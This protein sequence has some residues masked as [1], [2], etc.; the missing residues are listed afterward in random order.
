MN[1]HNCAGIDKKSHV[2]GQSQIK[3]ER[4]G[5]LRIIFRLKRDKVSG[6]DIIVQ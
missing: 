6:M 1:L 2:K 4:S 3:G 5:V